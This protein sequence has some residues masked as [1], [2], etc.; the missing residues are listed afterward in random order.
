MT[1]FM[2]TANSSQTNKIIAAPPN[3]IQKK[4]VTLYDIILTDNTVEITE[5]ILI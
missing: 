2:D 5:K 3:P 1:K 4:E